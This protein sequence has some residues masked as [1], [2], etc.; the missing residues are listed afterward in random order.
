MK[1]TDEQIKVLLAI[2]RK[3][4]RDNWKGNMTLTEYVD[5]WWDSYWVR[6]HRI[7]EKG[8]LI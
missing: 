6:R 4:D 2:Q 7:N 5:F 8:N 3:Y 1:P